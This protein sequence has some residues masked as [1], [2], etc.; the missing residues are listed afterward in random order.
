[1]PGMCREDGPFTRCR[2]GVK[3]LKRLERAKGIE[4]SYAAW[5]ATDATAGGAPLEQAIVRA[6]EFS[7]RGLGLL[8]SAAA[9]FLEIATNTALSNGCASA[10]KPAGGRLPIHSAPVPNDVRFASDSDHSR[11]G[12]KLHATGRYASL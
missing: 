11:W 12:A 6:R 9:V 1:M 10:A 2:H 4:P 3:L 5:E 7:T 8:S